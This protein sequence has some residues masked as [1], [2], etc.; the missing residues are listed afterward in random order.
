MKLFIKSDIGFMFIKGAVDKESN[1]TR[2]S[3]ST[4]LNCLD[5]ASNA[6]GV[7]T[8]ATANNPK[9]LGSPIVRRP[10]RF[11]RIVEFPNPDADCRYRYLKSLAPELN[12][13]KLAEQ[14]VNMSGLSYAQL[15]EIYIL[16]NQ[17][18]DEESREMVEKD[19]TEASNILM[20]NINKVDGACKT[21][22]STL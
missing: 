5:G 10:G 11:D 21:G 13:A 16:A 15:K 4:L 17:L 19:I 18:A 8:I 3:L 20:S 14:T 12:S 7:I 9:T 22:F 6:D 1:I 2:I